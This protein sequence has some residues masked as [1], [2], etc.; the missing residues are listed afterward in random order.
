MGEGGGSVH[1]RDDAPL[2]GSHPRPPRLGAAD[3][4]PPRRAEEIG[5][6]LHGADRIHERGAETRCEE[7]AREAAGEEGRAEEVTGAAA[8]GLLVFRL[9]GGT[10]TPDDQADV[11]RAA[12]WPH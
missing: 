3:D 12:G 7:G 11:P 6:R 1:A 5:K 2:L 10:V 8:V 4:R 9:A